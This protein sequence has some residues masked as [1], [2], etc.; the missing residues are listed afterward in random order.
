MIKV[1]LDVSMV[2]IGTSFT[3]IPRVLMEIV[4]RLGTDDEFD[5]NFLE[6]NQRMD[7]FRVLKTQEF[8]DFC[9]TKTDKR[10]SI[11]SN[12]FIPFD[13]LDKDSIFFDCDTSWKTRTRRSFLY[14]LLKKKNVKIVTLIYDIINIDYPQFCDKS[15]VM[16]FVDYF[17]ATLIYA[18]KIIVTSKDVK[19]AIIL[20][21]INMN[22]E[23]PE[24]DIIP[25]GGDFKKKENSEE[26]VQ[27]SVKDIVSK[28]KYLLMVGT[29]E[30]RKNHKLLIETY[31]RFLRWKIHF[32]FAGFSGQ[33][34][35]KFFAELTTDPDYQNGIWH[36]DNASDDD[37]DYLY[38]NAYAM[39]FPSYIEGYGLPI[40][41]SFVREVPVIAADTNINHEIAGDRALFFEQ[42][43][44]RELADI[45]IDLLENE[46]KYDSFRERVKGYVPKTWDD[47]VTELKKCLKGV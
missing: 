12:V 31:Q 27:S 13:G 44:S 42:D 17:G 35:D 24:I 46:S 21:C 4:K 45:V 16:N 30:P 11:R 20:R 25:L 2:M 40:I 10:H 19:D 37:I 43:N 29:I 14:P 5:L 7:A 33:G 22:I 36:V 26:N 32:V 9:N 15:D 34:M 47:T 18:D 6:Y 8:I 23:S 3:G 1:Y 39:V 41:E 38:K 28:G